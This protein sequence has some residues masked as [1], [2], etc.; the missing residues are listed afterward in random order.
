L[1]GS[2]TSD[3]VERMLQLTPLEQIRA[4]QEL[5]QIKR[6]EWSQEWLQQ[7]SAQGELHRARKAIADVLEARFDLVPQSLIRKFEQIDTL[8]TLEELLRQA[9]KTPDLKH[10]AH[11]VKIVLQ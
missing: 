4:V 7:G 2:V 10:F 9:V 5:L 8:Q 3:K 1:Q 6:Q 11:C